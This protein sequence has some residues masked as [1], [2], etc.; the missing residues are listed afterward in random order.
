MAS[1]T[2]SGIS[3]VLGELISP[4]PPATESP[5]SS[6]LAMERHEAKVIRH[7]TTNATSSTP[8][9]SWP[10]S[11]QDHPTPGPERE[12]DASHSKQ[13]DRRVPRLVMGSPLPTQRTCRTGARRLRRI[14]PSLSR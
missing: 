9:P 6:Q 1:K 2:I 13:P 8:C 10:A 3:G 7:R 14:A 4:A 12:S 11:W 5:R